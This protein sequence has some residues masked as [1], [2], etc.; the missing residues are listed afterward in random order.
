MKLKRPAIQ[1]NVCLFLSKNGLL[2]NR[3]Y[4]GAHLL[5]SVNGTGIYSSNK[6]GCSHD[7][8]TR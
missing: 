7:Y 2:E 1:K 5:V 3:R 4:L 6:M 8:S